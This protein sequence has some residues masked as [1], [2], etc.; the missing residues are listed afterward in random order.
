ME[1]ATDYMLD[2]KCFRYIDQL[3]GPHTVDR[4]ASIKTKQ[5]DRYCSR[6]RNPGCEASNA[7][8][9]SWSWDSN[10]IFPPPP[11]IPKVLRHMS[12]G[13]EY[14]TL[15]APEWPSAVWWPLLVGRSGT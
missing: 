5:L 8:T 3:R 1:D 6:Y 14:G 10:W 4:I 11:P 12:A 13:H 15:I 7:F 2:P 9:V